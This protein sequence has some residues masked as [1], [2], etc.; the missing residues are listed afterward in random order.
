MHVV[1]VGTL[2]ENGAVLLVH[3]GSTRRAYR[4]TPDGSGPEASGHQARVLRWSVVVA[5]DVTGARA[6]TD[7][8]RVH[9]PATLATAV[10]TNWV[11]CILL[12]VLLRD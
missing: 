4:L 9:L 12:C 7:R 8:G 10:R 5:A 3:R 1:V 11:R 2:V 6:V